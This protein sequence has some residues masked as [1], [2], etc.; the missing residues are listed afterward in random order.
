MGDAAPVPVTQRRQQA[1]GQP[2]C[3][4]RVPDSR[5]RLLI[6][7]PL[8]VLAGG[9][10]LPAGGFQEQQRLLAQTMGH[11]DKGGT[12]WGSPT[13]GMR[14]TCD[15]EDIYGQWLQWGQA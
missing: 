1:W 15:Q 4:G 13:M 10:H 8:Q 2:V 6:G 14:D 11:S 7:V 5:T 9:Y 12:H 3:Q